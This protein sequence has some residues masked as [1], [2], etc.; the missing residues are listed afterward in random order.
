MPLTKGNQEIYTHLAVVYDEVMRDIDYEDWADFIDAVIIKHNEDAVSILELACGTGSL[1]LSLDELDCY[2]ITA[3]D[4]SEQML[5]VARQKAA[6]K[7]SSINW[8]QID[9]FNINIS[10][11]YDVVLM[12]FDSINYIRDTES[13][14]LMFQQVRNILNEDGFLIFDFTTPQH[15]SK[16]AD[17][18]NDQ[19]VTHD[20]YRF[21]RISR[22]LDTEGVHYNEFTI[23]K[24]SDDKQNVLERK[25]EV[26]VQKAYKFEDIQNVVS[27]A[28]FTVVAAY[29]GVDLVEATPNSD[30][31]TMVIR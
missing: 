2:D 29:E 1:A 11:K 23:E 27:Q 21:V 8:K 3:S 24:L 13:M 4:Y 6:Y 16:Y 17:M 30:R 7:N 18:M 31:I 22:Y 26:H 12:L 14:L 28:G 25:N 9:F 19:G 15:S 10:E 20:N 5:E